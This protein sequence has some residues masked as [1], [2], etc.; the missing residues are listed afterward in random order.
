MILKEI[1]FSFVSG[2]ET[3]MTEV[4]TSDFI[5][6]LYALY[7]ITTRRSVMVLLSFISHVGVQHVAPIEQFPDDKWEQLIAVNLSASFHTMKLAVPGMKER[8]MLRT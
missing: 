8:G 5:V 6:L 1:Q 4:R 2:T 3:R 7:S